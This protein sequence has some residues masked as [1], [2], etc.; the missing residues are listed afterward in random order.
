MRTT[1]LA[2]YG[3]GMRVLDVRDARN[4][5]QLD[6]ATDGGHA[7]LGRLLDVARRR[8]TA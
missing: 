3:A 4:L 5:K 6:C 2:W 1:V 8:R 7:G